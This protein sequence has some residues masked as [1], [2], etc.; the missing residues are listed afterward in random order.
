VAALHTERRWCVTDRTVVFTPNAVTTR[1][2]MAITT[3]FQES[4]VCTTRT[5]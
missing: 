1:N 5:Y 4:G 3:L 2:G